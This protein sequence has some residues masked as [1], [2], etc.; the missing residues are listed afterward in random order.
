MII[1]QTGSEAMKTAVTAAC[2]LVSVFGQS[3]VALDLSPARWPATARERAEKQ[4]TAGWTPVEART[5]SGRSGVIS[6]T[7]SPIAVQAGLEALR[8]G[9]TA[10]DAAATVALTEIT[11]QLGSVV[12]YA[13]IIALVYYDAKT[14]K[15]YSLDAGYNSYQNETEPKTIPVADMG[16]LNATFTAMLPRSPW[17]KRR[18]RACRKA[19]KRSSR[20]SWLESR[21][22]MDDSV[23]WH[24][25][26]CS[27][28][29]SGMPSAA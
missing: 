10:A 13:G 23:V 8:Q 14:G 15:V 24:L 4:E 22:C 18:P 11:T 5:I 17:A 9:G 27:T 6:T 12:S 28:R 16:P 3:V 2:V 21:R 26:R 29:P 19:A 25:P 1:A 20:G 7:A